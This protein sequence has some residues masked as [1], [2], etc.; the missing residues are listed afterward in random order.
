M[1]TLEQF[2]Q[3][4]VLYNFVKTTPFCRK[5]LEESNNDRSI[6]M[7]YLCLLIKEELS[8]KMQLFLVDNIREYFDY[9]SGVENQPSEYQRHL[10][11]IRKI[12]SSLEK[13]LPDVNQVYEMR[14]I[15]DLFEDD[16]AYKYRKMW[17]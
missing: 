7:G 6:L 11:T 4:E 16:K 2:N 15:P 5:T 14:H 8:T 10:S 9:D 17:E 3:L 12:Q 13:K 1:F